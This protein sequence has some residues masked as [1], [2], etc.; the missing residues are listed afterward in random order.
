MN[1]KNAYLRTV[2]A[3]MLTASL[4]VT[5]C[6]ASSSAPVSKDDSTAPASAAAKKE[7]VELVVYHPFPADWPEDQFFKT[8]GD[9]IQKKFPH[10]KIKYITGKL[11]DLITAGQRID[12]IYVSIG[13]SQANILDT[14]LQSDISPLIKKYNYDLGRLEPTM[15]DAARKMAGGNGIYG[16]PVYVPPSA[17]YYNKDLFDKFGVPYPKDGMTWDELFEVSK[18]MTRSEGGASYYGFGSSYNHL[19]LMN[20]QSIPLVTSDKQATLDKDD[21]WK[22]FTD[23]LLR[24]YRLPGYEVFKTNQLS[25][26]Y[27]RNRFFKDRNVAMFLATTALHNETEVGDMNF[28][29]ASFPVFKDTPQAG[30]QP[31]PVYW[32]I[33]SQAEKRDDAFEAISYLTSDEYQ[34]KNIKEGNF[35]SALSN[36]SIREQ[37]G[38]DN[39]LYK[40]KNVKALQPT[41]YSQL[42][43]FNKYNSIVSGELNVGIRE[44]VTNKKDTNTV[45]REAAERANKKIQEQEA[46]NVKK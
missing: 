33:T 10:I 45:L 11:Q 31:Y 8:F 46:A 7:P 25:E 6:S 14:G 37:F 15:V 30:P 28:D 16:L 42:G 36:K 44:S 26:P 29:I 20:Q 34:L 3:T 19:A 18:K 27:E 4:F 23:N 1:R 40:G 41:N 2:A 17:I 12:L 13:A 9:P 35:L 32:Y 24:F 5:A 38:T 21:R 43:S 39:K 22:S